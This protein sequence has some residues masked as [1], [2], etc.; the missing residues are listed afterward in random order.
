MLL[1]LTQELVII[2]VLAGLF[3]S[4]WHHPFQANPTSLALQAAQEQIDFAFD[5]LR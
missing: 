4:D 5:H 3:T 1:R 2:A